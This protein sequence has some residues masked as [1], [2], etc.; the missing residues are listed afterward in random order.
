M[1]LVSVICLFG[2]LLA[3]CGSSATAT[4]QHHRV[5]ALRWGLVGASDL[6]TLDPALAS[7]ANSISVASLVYGGLVRLDGRLQVQPDGASHWKVGD[8]GRVYTFFLRKNLRFADGRRVTA[9]DFAFALR[10]ALGPGASAGTGV[11][12]LGAIARDGIAARNLGTLRITLAR[13][14]AHF[15]AELAFPASFVPDPAVIQRYGAVWTD[16]A[17]GFG[18]Y[19][20]RFWRHSRSL[21][22]APNPFYYGGRPKLRSIVLRFYDGTA[23]ATAAYAH[24]QLDMVSG[25]QPGEAVSATVPGVHRVPA[26]ALDYL[27]FNTRRFPFHHLNARRAFV[28]AWSRAAGQPSVG[29]GAFQSR[30]FLPSAFGLQTPTWRPTAKP[31]AFL[32]AAHYGAKHPFPPVDL[33]MLRDPHVYALAQ[34]LVKQWHDSLGVDVTVRQ[35]NLSDYLVL[36]NRRL[37]DMA[38]V[39]WGGDYPDPQDFLGTQLGASPDNV[40]GWVGRSYDKTV[41]QADSYA[42]TD[43]RRAELFQ[44]AS[45]IAAVKVPVLPLDEPAQTALLVSGLSGVQLTSLGTMTADW[46]QATLTR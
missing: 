20:V 32:K 41:G 46:S 9:S 27:A 43:P 37:F 6:P 44:R 16:H 29:Q 21:T 38:L 26:L 19:V 1:R 40:T 4:P 31:P 30:T 8:G 36:L 34:N 24:G 13:P 17:T 3:G 12:Y 5:D 23:S 33:V 42:P 45:H 14:S 15:L 22:L 25:F 10:R 28:A 2:L 11:F 18:P 7:D 35:F 39:R